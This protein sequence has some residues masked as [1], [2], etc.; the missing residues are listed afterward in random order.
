[1]PVSCLII[2]V[3]PKIHVTDRLEYIL[4]T[5]WEKIATS[6]YSSGGNSLFNNTYN[7]YFIERGKLYR[8]TRTQEFSNIRIIVQRAHSN[9][10]HMIE[11]MINGKIFSFSLEIVSPFPMLP[12]CR[13]RFNG[14][15]NYTDIQKASRHEMPHFP[16]V[17][18]FFCSENRTILLN[19]LNCILPALQVNAT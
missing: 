5:A 8:S 14:Y 16:I 1:M 4:S 17:F 10:E 12:R 9:I 7:E 3:L 13:S 6:L 19:S 15:G 2:T 11:A 18:Y